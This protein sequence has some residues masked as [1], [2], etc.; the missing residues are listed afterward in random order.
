MQKKGSITPTHGLNWGKG[1]TAALN[2]QAS[3]QFQITACIPG[4]S[5]GTSSTYL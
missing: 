2:T 1:T 4:S 3:S 5:E